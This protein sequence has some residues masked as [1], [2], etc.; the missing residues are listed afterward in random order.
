MGRWI[1]R[2]SYVFL[3]AF[4]TSSA[5]EVFDLRPG[6]FSSAP[7][8][9]AAAGTQGDDL[10]FFGL[11]D[12]VE[13]ALWR[14]DGDENAIRSLGSFGVA[15]LGIH[16][17]T[18]R[19]AGSFAF[20]V[21]TEEALVAVTTQ[22]VLAADPDGNVETLTPRLAAEPLGPTAY[23]LAR[24]FQI[25]DKL[26]FGDSEGRLWSSQGTTD[27][28]H[29]L[30]GLDRL[31][32]E[33]LGQVGDG[34]YLISVTTI[35]VG[36]PGIEAEVWVTDGTVAGTHPLGPIDDVA[37]VEAKKTNVAVAG[38]VVF[39]TEGARALWWSDGTRAGTRELQ[40]DNASPA[41]GGTSRHVLFLGHFS[42]GFDTVTVLFSATPDGETTELARTMS[43]QLTDAAIG[44]LQPPCEACD[45]ERAFFLT[46]Q[47]T[48]LVP[49]RESTISVTDGTEE[50]TRVVLTRSDVLP[51]PSISDGNLARLGERL[52][53]VAD[54]QLWT[55]D[56]TAAGTR[57]I[58]PVDGGTPLTDPLLDGARE[59]TAGLL[60][61]AGGVLWVTDGTDAGTRMLSPEARTPSLSQGLA[62]DGTLLFAAG[63]E[64]EQRVLWGSDGT[65]LGTAPIPL[66][67][68]GTRVMN[69]REM[70]LAD[71]RVFL[72][73]V[74]TLG[75]ELVALPRADVTVPRLDLRADDRFE[76]VVRWHLPDGESGWGT[77]VRLTTDTGHFWF[78]RD[79]NVELVIKV[80][81]GRR[82]NGHWWVF[83]GALSNVAYTISVRDKATGA[84]KVY[85][86][87]AGTFGSVG[88]TRAFAEP[89]PP[90]SGPSS[91]GPSS[92]GPSS[93]GP[94]SSGQASSGQAAS[95]VSRS[96][97][98][99]AGPGEPVTILADAVG[100]LAVVGAPSVLGPGSSPAVQG[101]C[102]TTGRSLVPAAV[103]LHGRGR[104]GE[105]R[106]RD[107]AG[108]RGRAD[109]GHRLLLV[110]PRHQCR[111]GGQGSRRTA[112]QRSLV[113]VLRCSV[114][115]SLR[116][117]RHRYRD[118]SRTHL[119]ES[120]R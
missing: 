17:A 38:G 49:L 48:G 85:D 61:Q 22:S 31:Y 26:L 39:R 96:L 23:D 50:G 4:A 12:Q 66:D 24:A 29:S 103:T 63:N 56:G 41:L 64:Q 104:M 105:S 91:P 112:R 86:N 107:G 69:P 119:H 8:N 32:R 79:S 118:R 120:R 13:W 20:F 99:N 71:N 44:L 93:S 114:E 55:S 37:L 117:H 43:G 110:L 34:R 45:S 68:A 40:R 72:S 106:W 28:T 25:D 101:G 97:A 1:R 81:D 54:N 52:F 70:T 10:F 102:V 94:S 42:L 9:L 108:H 51:A 90:L 59:V 87:P 111:S 6:P 83:Y 62:L 46:E 80:L 67:E 33:T 75:D 65:A 36:A 82:S 16:P 58:Q 77:P 100:R 11:V 89:A 53:F 88:D 113:G 109:P 21:V 74:T 60:F 18:L 27:T 57:Q 5:A 98:G 7:R 76:L 15:P 35:G 19:T 116:A 84:V 30:L 2:V 14:Y 95:V 115:R 78:F 3:V 73:A 92:P 47:T